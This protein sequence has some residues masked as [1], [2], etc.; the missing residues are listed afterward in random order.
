MSQDISLEVSRYHKLLGSWVL[1]RTVF[2]KPTSARRRKATFHANG[3]T[4]LKVKFPTLPPLEAFHS[5]LSASNTTEQQYEYCQ[6]VWRD[7][8]METF[9]DFFGVVVLF[10]FW[11]LLKK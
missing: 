11:K 10:P 8:N 1:L 5:T 9:R 7:N 3:S 6:R 2:S 4:P